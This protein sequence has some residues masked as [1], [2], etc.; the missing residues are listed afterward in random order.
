MLFFLGCAPS[1]T[2][3]QQ[4]KLIS[5]DRSFKDYAESG[6]VVMVFPVI[7]NGEYLSAIKYQD[8][9]TPLEKRS[10]QIILRDF[11]KYR[12]SLSDPL[13]VKNLEKL[14]RALKE[15][16]ILS[17]SE[18]LSYFDATDIDYLLL[19]RIRDSFKVVSGSGSFIKHL[20]IEGEMWDTDKKGVVWRASSK[21]ECE[22][23]ISDDRLIIDAIY[24]LYPKLPKFYYN[25]DSR[26]W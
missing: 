2:T 8:I 10:D 13:R 16:K 23:D 25:S 17:I 12:D 11:K 4:V 22:S 3:K 21:V 26:D 20:S 24:S 14:N 18:L 19:F 15:E 5:M 7:M 9:V 6:R 1:A